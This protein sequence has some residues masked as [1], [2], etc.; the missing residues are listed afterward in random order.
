LSPQRSVPYNDWENEQNWSLDLD[1]QNE[2]AMTFAANSEV[3]R[4]KLARSCP[5]RAQSP[6][7]STFGRKN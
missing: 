2:L 4:R 7:G 5:I 6:D 3:N 1:K